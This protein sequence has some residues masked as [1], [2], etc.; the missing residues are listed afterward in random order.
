MIVV[1]EGISAAG[2]TNWCCTHATGHVLSPDQLDKGV[3][4]G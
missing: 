2:K 3:A 4:R 1:V